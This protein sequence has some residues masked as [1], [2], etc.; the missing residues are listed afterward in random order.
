MRLDVLARKP[1]L[2]NDRLMQTREANT[3]NR[4]RGRVGFCQ[5]LRGSSQKEWAVLA[6]PHYGQNCTCI[7]L[8]TQK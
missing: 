7:V 6:G 5:I 1:V 8:A 4:L 3:L 2:V